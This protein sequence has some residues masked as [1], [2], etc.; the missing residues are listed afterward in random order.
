MEAGLSIERTYHL[1][2]EHEFEQG[3]EKISKS[4][5]Y[6]LVRRLKP[7]IV[8]VKKRKQG[9]NNPQDD[10]CRARYLFSK[11]LL[12][13]FGRLTEP[14]PRQPC[15]DVRQLG[16]LDIHQVVWWDETHRKCVIGGISASRMMALKFQRD[17][18][19]KL[20]KN[21]EYSEDKVEVLNC[22]Y[23]KEGRFGLGCALT[24]EID[25]QWNLRDK[26]KTCSVFDYSGKTII[27]LNDYEKL[28]KQEFHRIS[29]LSDKSKH[30][31]HDPRNPQ[32]L[33]QDDDLLRL[34]KVGKKTKEKLENANI[35]CVGD[36]K[37]NNQP[38]P[39]ITRASLQFLR[40]QAQLSRD[41]NAPLKIDHRKAPNPYMSRYG[42]NWENV[43][44]QS[45]HFSSYVVITD[46]IEHIVTESQKIMK[47]TLYEDD[48]Y[49]YHDALSLMTSAK[50]KQWMKDKNYYKHWILPKNKLYAQDSNALQTKYGDNPIGNSP[51]FM[52]WDSHLNQD[53]HSA[54]D[55]HV[56]LT[57][58]L[59]EDDPRKFSG[60]TP[61]RMSSSYHRLIEICPS[62]KRIEQDCSRVLDAF[63]A[64]M[65]AR[66]CIVE[67]F[68]Q[69]SGRRGVSANDSTR[70]GKRIKKPY[71]PGQYLHPS[72]ASV[73][74]AMIGQS[75]AI[76]DYYTGNDNDENLLLIDSV[77]NEADDVGHDEFPIDV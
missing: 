41:E 22:K 63:R 71:E 31:I 10:W 76:N 14:H 77:A 62:P 59:P 24:L 69:R 17:E 5:I 18:N 52:P 47:G 25:E 37:R 50:T 57:R 74:E 64:V 55:Q 8:N 27:T 68:G 65:E 19:G 54:H 40:D 9:S 36:L 38:V 34:D 2:N 28:K 26:G 16:T 30:W 12:I 6:N 33:F 42:T 3:N 20:D 35:R 75:I 23:E 56:A 53:L 45:S 48:W 29:T 13:R 66:G 51:E 44:K 60:S 49:F 58:H 43:L 46:Y 39:G 1:L 67:K 72:V 11:Q 32:D 21:G 7:K 70:G 4:A 61:S 15:F 73:S